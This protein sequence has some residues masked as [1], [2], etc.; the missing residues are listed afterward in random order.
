MRKPDILCIGA[1]KAG[2]TWFHSVFGARPDVWVPPFKEMHFFDHIYG[3]DSHRWSRGHIMRSIKS[4]VRYH[5]E[6][7]SNLSMDYLDYLCSLTRDDMFTRRWYGR[8]WERAGEDKLALDVTPEYSCISPEGV[9]HFKRMLGKAKIIY[10][11]RDPVSRAVS[12]IR[13]GVGRRNTVPK[14]IDDWIAEIERPEIDN[15]GDYKTYIPRWQGVYKEDQLLFMP[16]KQIAT[17]PDG[18]LRKVETFLGLPPAI[19]PRASDRVHGGQGLPVPDEVKAILQK[20][21]AAQYAY[22]QDSFAPEFIAQM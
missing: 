16:F 18:F 2:T 21:Y 1:Q 22:L 13:M 14:T 4:A 5:V 8:I 6:N 20:R 11:L 17:D 7:E 15:R 19:Y 3:E 12:Q 10:I 9:E